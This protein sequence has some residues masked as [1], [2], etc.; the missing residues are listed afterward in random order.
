MDL[1]CSWF[2]IRSY[3][4]MSL[5]EE[6]YKK[7]DQASKDWAEAEKKV[8][9]LEEGKKATFSKLVLKHKKL[10][11]TISEAE[12]HA[13]SDKEYQDIIEQ[14]SEA[15]MNL[16]KCRYHYNNIDKYVSLKQSELKR[17]LALSGKV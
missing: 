7:L 1:L 11:K 5:S 12:Y 3:I 15:S 9:I 17:D 16:I 8:I 2:Y 4:D 10:V 13:R 14:Y 6:L